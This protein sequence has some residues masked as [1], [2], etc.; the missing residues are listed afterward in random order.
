MIVLGRRP[1]FTGKTTPNF[2]FVRAFRKGKGRHYIVNTAI[3]A[4]SEAAGHPAVAGKWWRVQVEVMADRRGGGPGW[5]YSDKSRIS[6]A[7]PATY[8]PFYL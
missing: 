8:L 6:A 7:L 2:R 3:L 5:C 4:V 1:Q